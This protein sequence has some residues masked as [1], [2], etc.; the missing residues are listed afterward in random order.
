[1]DLTTLDF[2]YSYS[3]RSVWINTSSI[4]GVAKIYAYLN[5]F[6]AIFV[7]TAGSLIEIGPKNMNNGLHRA[8]DNNPQIQFPGKCE[9]EQCV[10]NSF[11]NRNITRFIA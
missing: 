10:R 5:A 6:A 7:L 8:K 2:A 9:L 11:A 4:S 1:M 3:V